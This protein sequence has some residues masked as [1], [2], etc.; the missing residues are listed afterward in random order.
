MYKHILVP[1]DG[2]ALSLKA[3][4]TAAKLAATLKA[5]ITAIYVIAPFT[6]QMSSEGMMYTAAY[7]TQEYERGMRKVADKALAKVQ[8]A[9]G[10]V[11]CGA[12]SVMSINPWEA[13]VKTAASRKCDLIV[14]ASHGRRGLTGLLLGSE[15]QKVLTHSKVP[16][17]VCR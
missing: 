11:K 4:R 9:A 13:I 12:V 5:R 16:V 15:T 2:S 7:S 1:T 6:P 3:A 14:M 17:L 10:S 8:A